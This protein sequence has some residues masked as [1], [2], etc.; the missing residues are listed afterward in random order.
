M[1]DILVVD[2]EE[3]IADSLRILLERE[4]YGVDIAHSGPS[5]MLKMKKKKYDLVLLDLFMPKISGREVAEKIRKDQKLKEQKIVFLTIAK[6]SE[7]GHAEIEKLN[8]VDYIVKPID[9]QDFR[10]RI[11]K[12]LGE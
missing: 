1:V 11:Q 6:L 7:A 3:D 12:A 10:E 5:G 9:N 4:G 8:P 2:D